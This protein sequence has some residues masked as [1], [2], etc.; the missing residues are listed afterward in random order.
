MATAVKIARAELSAIC[1]AVGV[2]APND[3]VELHDLPLVMRYTLDVAAAHPETA[4]FAD[5]LRDRVLPVARGQDW[6]RAR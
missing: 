3:S 4:P 1:R 6:Y 2:M 5:W